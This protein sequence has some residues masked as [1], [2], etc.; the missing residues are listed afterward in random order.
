MHPMMAGGRHT[1]DGLLPPAKRYVGSLA[2]S[3]G[4]PFS[5]VEGKRTDAAGEGSEIDNLLKSVL[6]TEDLWRLQ[7]RALKQEL[8]R[9]QEEEIDNQIAQDGTD[10]EKRNVGSLARSGNMPFKN[11]KRSVE[12]LARAGYLPVPKQQHDSAEYPQESGENSEEVL[13]KRNIAALA[14]NGQLGPHGLKD[15]FHE[16]EGNR[17]D[18]AYVEYLHQKRESDEE[19]EGLDELIQELYEEG[20]DIGKRNIGS[21]ARGHNFPYHGGKRNLGSVARA[22]GFRFGGT[23]KKDDNDE[24]TDYDKRS[25][26]SLIRNAIN[27][28]QEEKRYIGSVM[29]NQGSR[30]GVSKK[31]DF[32]TEDEEKRNIAAIA[33]NWHLPEHLKYDKRLDDEEEGVEDAAKRYVA[34]LLRHGSLPVGAA[35]ASSEGPEEDKRHI[36]SLASKGSFHIQKKSSRSTGSDVVAYNST[37]QAETSM[38]AKRSVSTSQ[39]AT[40]AVPGNRT[41]RQAVLVPAT[42]SDEYPVPVMQTSDLFDYEDLAELLSG[43]AAPEKR[44]LGEYSR[45]L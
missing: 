4:L 34:A 39:Q 14:K 41:K 45:F 13:G 24:N 33:R 30:F 6:E 26:T 19:G 29:R 43:D 42:S 9:E 11:G 7:L 18:D 27:P 28:F 15:L 16:E 25:V 10:E 44:F 22:G 32:E 35:A 1:A 8:L 40:A 3:G 2:R 5:R 17:G 23:T 31:D 20:E 12:A 38:K 36:G 21:L 37:Q